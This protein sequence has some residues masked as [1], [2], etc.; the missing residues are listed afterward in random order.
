MVIGRRLHKGGLTEREMKGIQSSY[1]MVRAE[2]CLQ[3][4]IKVT[5]DSYLMINLVPRK[6]EIFHN[7]RAALHCM[8]LVRLNCLWIQ[9]QVVIKE[10]YINKVFAHSLWLHHGRLP[11]RIVPRQGEDDHADAGPHAELILQV[12]QEFAV[13]LIKYCNIVFIV[14]FIISPLLVIVVGA[15]LVCLPT[16][17]QFTT[18][19]TDGRTILYFPCLGLCKFC[20][21]ELERP[22]EI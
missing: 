10:Y 21:Q 20:L 19:L 9:S 11:S 15:A 2:K 3:C 17:I 8:K 1:N 5:Y 22:L 4:S 12:N 14:Y 6:K 7:D 18:K 13:S 16:L